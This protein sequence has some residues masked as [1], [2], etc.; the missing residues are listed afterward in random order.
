MPVLGIGMSLLLGLLLWAIGALQSVQEARTTV[1]HVVASA[2]RADSL[3]AYVSEG[4]GGG[5]LV[6]SQSQAA[7]ALPGFLETAWPG[8]TAQWTT[9]GTLDL[10]PPPSAQ[11]GLDLTA[12]PIVLQNLQVVDTAPYALTHF[13]RTTYAP[14][15]A[16]AVDATAAVRIPF[17]GGAITGTLQWPITVPLAGST[18]P[19]TFVPLS[20]S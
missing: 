13:G 2:L 16:L 6:L 4:L 5:Q 14:G 3:S 7:A 8:S 11:A 19:G 18:A 20:G 12:G 10:T 17:F 1:H 9:G 15:P